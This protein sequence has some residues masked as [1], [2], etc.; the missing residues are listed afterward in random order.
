MT[1]DAGTCLCWF[2][3]NSTPVSDT[4]GKVQTSLL[5]VGLKASLPGD[6]ATLGTDMRG[7]VFVDPLVGRNSALIRQHHG[8]GALR[9]RLKEEQ[10][11]RIRYYNSSNPFHFITPGIGAKAHRV[12]STSDLLEV[13]DQLS[14]AGELCLAL[15]TLEV[16]V[17]QPFGLLARQRHERLG[18]LRCAAD[19]PRLRRC[20][21]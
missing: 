5:Q 2:R 9:A 17:L 13:R 1:S 18:A 4:P 11:M 8:R 10:N 3:N 19:R 16:V 14:L 12:G 15:W 21:S 7:F 20:W 6:A